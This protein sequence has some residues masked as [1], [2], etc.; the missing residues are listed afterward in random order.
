MKNNDLINKRINMRRIYQFISFKTLNF[1]LLQYRKEHRSVKIIKINPYN[2]SDKFNIY[3]ISS[4]FVFTV[5]K[6][7]NAIICQNNKILQQE[8]L[9]NR[10]YKEIL[11]KLYY[12]NYYMNQLSRVCTLKNH[13]DEQVEYLC[14]DPECKSSRFLCFMCFQEGI[15]QH[16]NKGKSVLNQREFIDYFGKIKDSKWT[17][18]GFCFT[19]VKYFGQI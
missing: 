14:V 1:K 11:N 7:Y 2:I 6:F 13:N 15:H 4:S 16:Q 3:S 12:N 10:K 5:S 17:N 18:N 9:Q 8:R 19:V